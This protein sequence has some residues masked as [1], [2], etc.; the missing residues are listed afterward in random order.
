MLSPCGKNGVAKD[1][2]LSASAPITLCGRS[3]SRVFFRLCLLHG[4]EY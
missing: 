3:K 1:N 2:F 4:L